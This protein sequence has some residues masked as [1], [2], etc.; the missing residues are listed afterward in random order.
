MATPTRAGGRPRRADAERSI[1]AIVQAA[2]EALSQRPDANLSDIARDAGVGRVTL[3]AHFPTRERLIE[4]AVD[5]AVAEAVSAIAAADVERGPADEALSRLVRLAWPIL[6]RHRG[7]HAAAAALHPRVLRE[8]H[9]AVLDQFEQLIAR[10]QAD[11]TIRTDLPSEWLVTVCY[12]L[13]HGAAEAVSQ[14]RID[15]VAAADALDKSIRGALAPLPSRRSS[16][17]ASR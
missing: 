6:D 3:Y 13:M 2:V 14:D 10:G 1:A 7:L 16:S 12:S 15:R 4:A 9:A 5:H 17:R 11:G 8:R